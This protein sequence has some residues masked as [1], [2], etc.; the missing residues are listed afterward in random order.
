[1]KVAPIIRAL[2]GHPA[3]FEHTLVHTGQHYSADM[4]DSFFRDLGIPAPDINLEVGSGSHAEQTAA[5]MVGMEPVLRSMKPDMVVVV[6]DVNSTVA[7]ALTAKKLNLNVAHVEAGLR[8]FDRTMPE[9]INRLCTDSI[10]DLLFTTDRMASEQLLREGIAADR[11]HFVGNVM[12]DSLLTHVETAERLAFHTSFGVK[13]GGY[14]VLT[15]HRPA[16]V[17]DPANLATILDAIRLALPNLPVIFPVHPRTRGR[18]EAFGLQDRFSATSSEPG[19]FLTDPLGYVEFLSLNRGAR[20]VLTDSGGLQEETTVLGVPCVTLREN[21]ERPVTVSEG[22]NCLGG[23]AH[24][25]IVAAIGQALAMKAADGRRPEKWDGRTAERI[26]DVL[27]AH[28]G[29]EAG[30]P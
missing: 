7:A 28:L 18:I 5:V 19:I 20:L 16:N 6:G 29:S 26:A 25:G 22:T 11:I 3:G 14:G 8:S 17:E 27:A 13:P 10:S 23:T 15:L 21:T 12:I 9:E 4:S 30:G 2:A 24:D 1:M